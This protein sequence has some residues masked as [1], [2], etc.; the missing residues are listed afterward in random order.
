MDVEYKGRS[1]G[2]IVKFK[3]ASP[4]SSHLHAMRRKYG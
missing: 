2:K 1:I 3:S 4:L